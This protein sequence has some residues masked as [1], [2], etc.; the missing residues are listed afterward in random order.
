MYHKI[1]PQQAKE[2]LDSGKNLVLLDVRTR[3][4]YRE[5]SI[6]GALLLPNESIGEDTLRQL[7]DRDVP[8]LV[9]CRSGRRSRQAAEKL[10]RLGYTQVYDFGGILDWPYGTV[11]G[12][13][14]QPH[15]KGN[16]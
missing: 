8:L 14:P 9:Y 4:E 10:V 16:Q 11:S 13:Q 7:P 6:Q 12:G 15:Q 2:F 1:T 5:R 3:P